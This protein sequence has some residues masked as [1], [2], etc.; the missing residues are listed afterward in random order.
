MSFRHDVIGTQVPTSVIRRTKTPEPVPPADGWN[1][2]TLCRKPDL[3][4]GNSVKLKSTLVIKSNRWRLVLPVRE[5]IAQDQVVHLR[6][7]ETLERVHGR[8]NWRITPHAQSTVDHRLVASLRFETV[9]KAMVAR[10]C[11]VVNGLRT[12]RVIRMGSSVAHQQCLRTVHFRPEL[13]PDVF[14]E[15]RRREGID[16]IVILEHA[17]Y[18]LLHLLW[19]RVPE[20]RPR[21]EQTSPGIDGTMS[22]IPGILK[23]FGQTS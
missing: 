12:R 11:L 2:N 21:A 20:N 7:H 22:L 16:A 8:A 23:G 17:I 1:Q 19:A 6:S 15:H 4:H 5:A 14:S 13:A 10:I 9:C 18:C 3:L